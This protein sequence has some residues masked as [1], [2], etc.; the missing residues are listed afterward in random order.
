LDLMNARILVVDDQEEQI[1]LLGAILRRAGYRAVKTTMDSTETLALCEAFEPDLIVLDLNMPGM[2]GFEALTPDVKA[3]V[4]EPFF[5]TKPAGQGTGLGLALSMEIVRSHGG[6]LEVASEPG[7]GATFSIEL[8]VTT[9]G[10]RPVPERRDAKGAGHGLRVLVV[11]DEREVADVLAD[12]LGADGHRVEV[13]IDGGEALAA[14]RR[15]RHDVA[16]SDVRMPGVG[17]AEIARALSAR[18]DAGSRLVL[19]TGDD[20]S[21][22]TARVLEEFPGAMLAKPFTWAEVRRVLA[23]IT[24]ERATGMSPHGSYRAP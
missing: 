2:D 14:I 4:F 16:F 3:R 15:N 10:A 22:G 8:P 18:G 17:G 24:S 12:M 23:R 6:A 11:D 19:V 9:A 21:A 7:R 5:T 13:L 1:V 20:M